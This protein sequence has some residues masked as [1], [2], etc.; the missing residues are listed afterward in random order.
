V[1]LQVWFAA[2]VVLALNLLAFAAQ[3]VDKQLAKRGA[4]RIS[5]RRL[6]WF[7][8]LLGAPGMWLGMQT[9]RHKTSKSSFRAYAWLVTAINL[10]L[11]Y[12]LFELW[13]SGWLAFRF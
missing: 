7:G 3:G 5:E 13:R 6:L 9:F 11:A 2:A 10:A 12:G 1:T 8:A 4:R